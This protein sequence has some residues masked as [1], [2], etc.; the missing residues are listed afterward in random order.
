[1]VSRDVLEAKLIGF[2]NNLEAGN[3]GKM[4][5]MIPVILVLENRWWYHLLR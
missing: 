5:K 4:Q 1:M 3:E 2:S